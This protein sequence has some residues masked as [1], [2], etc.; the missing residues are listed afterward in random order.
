MV[1]PVICKRPYVFS[2]FRRVEAFRKRLSLCI[3]VPVA[4]QNMGDWNR[5]QVWRET[6]CSL[7]RSTVSSHILTRRS[8]VGRGESPRKAGFC[9]LP[10]LGLT[11][12]SFFFLT[13]EFLNIARFLW[14]H[15]QTWAAD[16][17]SALRGHSHG[18]LQ[19]DAGKRCLCSASMRLHDFL[20]TVPSTN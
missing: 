8:C 9:C 14:E 13:L 16:V 15:P 4:P 6:Y 17:R 2:L 5:A 7:P 20:N 19:A 3:H 1:S 11:G 10:A 18:H 12:F